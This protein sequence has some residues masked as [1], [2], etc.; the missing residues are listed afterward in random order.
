MIKVSLIL[1]DDKLKKVLENKI[2]L[3]LNSNSKEV[4]FVQESY[5]KDVVSDEILIL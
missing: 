2:K 5:V 3:L 1:K 4:Y